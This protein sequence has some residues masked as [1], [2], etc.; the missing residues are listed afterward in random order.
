MAVLPNTFNYFTAFQWPDPFSLA[1]TNGISVD[2]FSS[3]YLDVS[4][5]RVRFPY[6]CIQ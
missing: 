6:L 3:G 5:L 4:V 2:F 1:T